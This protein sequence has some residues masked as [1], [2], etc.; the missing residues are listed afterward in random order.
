MADRFTIL[1]K[2]GAG[3]CVGRG[4]VD[5]LADRCERGDRIGGVIIDIDNEDRAEEF[6]GEEGMRGVRGEVDG[7]VDE[8]AGSV[9][10]GLGWVLV[11]W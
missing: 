6:A 1:C 9:V 10:V 5:G 11:V 2:D 7:G 4:G 3:Q 8:E